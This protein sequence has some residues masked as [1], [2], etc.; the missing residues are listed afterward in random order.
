M[1]CYG[2]TTTLPSTPYFCSSFSKKGTARSSRHNPPPAHPDRVG[3][4]EPQPIGDVE[5]HAGGVD[6]PGGMVRPD[7]GPARQR[8]PEDGEDVEGLEAVVGQVDER[9]A[10]AVVGR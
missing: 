8:L 6:P 2:S 9:P 1:D 10:G 3:G 7:E 5:G 4:G